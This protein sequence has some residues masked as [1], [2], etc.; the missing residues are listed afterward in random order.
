MIMNKYIL[1]LLCQHF[2]LCFCLLII[3][4]ILLAKPTHPYLR[5]KLDGSC[6]VFI[7]IPEK[8]EGQSRVY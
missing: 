1:F 8:I 6:D 3:P 5:M 4:I 2:A 7:C